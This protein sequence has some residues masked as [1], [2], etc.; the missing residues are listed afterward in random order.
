MIHKKFSYNAVDF[1]PSTRAQTLCIWQ[2]WNLWLFCPQQHCWFSVC[3]TVFKR[4]DSKWFFMKQTVWAQHVFECRLRQSQQHRL[5]H[6]KMFK[7]F[8]L[9]LSSLFL[10]KTVWALEAFNVCQ[11]LNRQLDNIAV[12]NCFTSWGQAFVLPIQRKRR[13]WLLYW[14]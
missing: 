5:L 1:A 2:I 11:L 6:F 4:K 12:E 14:Y 7:V 3:R 10:K 13:C 8:D 9:K